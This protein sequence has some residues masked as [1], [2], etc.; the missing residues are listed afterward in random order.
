MKKFRYLFQVEF[1]VDGGIFEIRKSVSVEFVLR[2]FADVFAV[3]PTEF[4]FVENRRRFGNSVER[5]H[6]HHFGERHFFDVALGR[7]AEKGY[8]VYNRLFQITFLDEIV[9]V[10]VAVTFGKFSRRV[11]HYRG[12]V[13]IFRS[14]PPER[15]VHKII[16]RSGRKI[17]RSSDNVSYPHK[18][19][20]DN[21]REVI[22]RHAVA[23][24][25]NVIFEIG[26][27][28]SYR[29]VNHIFVFADAL[30]G[31]VLTDNVRFAGGEFF[32]YF[33]LGKFKAMFVVFSVS[34]LVGERFEPF[35]RAETIVR[36]AEF[37]EFFRVLMINFLSFALNVRTVISAHVGTFVVDKSRFFKGTVNKFDRPLDVTLLV[38]VFYS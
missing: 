19:V 33:F 4:H 10:R 38:G 23:L 37:D 36:P 11:L 3:E 31:D 34:V 25:Q 6:F 32:L 8:V 14:F 21:V 22:S 27:I 7:P 9:E 2:K 20:V 26:V 28:D 29:A 13:N 5:E 30:G 17:F 16:F 35:F 18:V 12:Q 1:S 15:V 24:Y